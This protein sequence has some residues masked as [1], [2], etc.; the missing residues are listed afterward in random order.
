MHRADLPEAKN[1]SK[2]NIQMKFAAMVDAYIEF[3]MLEADF[4]VFKQTFLIQRSVS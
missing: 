3:D 1:I 4:G 2:D